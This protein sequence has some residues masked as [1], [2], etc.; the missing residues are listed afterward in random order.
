M[1]V[2]TKSFRTIWQVRGTAPIQIEVIDQTALPHRFSTKVITTDT[3]MADAISTMVVRGAPLIGV[4]G[5]YGMALAAQL[6]PSDANLKRA[7]AMLVSAR[8]TAVNLEWGVNKMLAALQAAPQDQRS[9]TGFEFAAAIAES[10]VRACELL[11]HHGARHIERIASGK[12]KGQPVNVLTHCNAGWLATV[13]WGTALAPIFAAHLKGI[14]VHVYV[15]E[16]RPR[17]QGLLT[18]WE[19]R[20][21]GIPFTLIVDN[22]GGH[23]MQQGEIDLCLV[24]SDRTAANGDVANKIGTYLKAL[25]AHDN[26]VEFYAVVPISS[27]DFSLTDG[28]QIPIENRHSQEVLAIAG[29]D[30]L[31]G[32]PSTITLAPPDTQ[33]TNPAFDVTPARLV[34]GIVTEFGTFSPDELQSLRTRT[35]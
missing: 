25:A 4:A 19:L 20:N 13:D 22:A 26:G 1:L 32:D 16:T 6:D 23:L 35:D 31:T 17:N 18:A 7:A 3:E 14:K 9:R 29:L 15:D 11:G 34:T 10:D 12:A 28:G 30:P 27:I 2:N 24:G 21:M 5:A 33:V 8:P